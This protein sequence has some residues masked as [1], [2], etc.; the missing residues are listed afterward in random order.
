M[1]IATVLSAHENSEVYRDT[2]ESVR[3]YLS[4]DVV[5]LVDGFGWKQFR[6]EKVD[7][8]EGF[9]HGRSSAP[10]RNMA[11]GLMGAWERWNSSAE[12]YCYI[13]YDCLVGSH[14]VHKHLAMADERGYWLL[15][16]GLRESYGN[17]PD[18]D[19]LCGAPNI[20]L[21]SLLGCCLFF[22][23]RFMSELNRNDFFGRFLSYTNF[24]PYEFKLYSDDL[25]GNYLDHKKPSAGR[26]VRPLPV[27]DTNEFIYPSV[28]I[29]YG[30]TVQEL[31]KWDVVNHT[32][33]GNFIHY[34]MRFSPDLGVSDPF[35]EACVMHPIKEADNPIRAYHKSLRLLRLLS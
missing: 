34:P 10:V 2:L 3:K 33:E 14:E 7:K 31:A 9:R 32:W 16:N 24:F 12:W 27:H 13:E 19:R 5:V 17:M 20:K 22:S 4:E 25:A 21:C 30:G 29:H 8:I 15:G 18:L 6:D 28:A 1:K 35:Q 26:P 23:A 11:L